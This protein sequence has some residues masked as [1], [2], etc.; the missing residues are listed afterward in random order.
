LKLQVRHTTRF[1]YPS[2]IVETHMELRLRP[3]DGPTQRVRAFELTVRP[4]VRVRSYLDGLGNHAHYFNCMSAH[5]EVLVSSILAVETAAGTAIPDTHA[6]EPAPPEVPVPHDFLRFRA[7]V[8]DVPAV[9]ELAACHTTRDAAS[10]AETLEAMDGLTLLVAREFE[11]RPRTTTVNTAVDDV[12][13]LRGGVCQDF[14]HL[15]IA[16]A[17]AAGIPAR[18]V[19]GYIYAGAGEETVGASHA[20]VEA[21]VPGRGWVGYDATHPVR[22]VENHVR[23]AVGRDYRDAAPTRGVYVGAAAGRMEVR[24]ETR[25][26]SIE[27]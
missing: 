10:A 11:Y 16:L 9:R 26:L 14:A 27:S 21:F 18:Y 19:S 25:P 13:R 23:V 20:W 5:R 8:V 12:I 1:L 3:P 2:P 15:L 7:P 6:A 17:R 24:V 4:Q 22:A